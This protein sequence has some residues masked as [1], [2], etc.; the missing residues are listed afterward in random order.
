M[1]DDNNPMQSARAA[2]RCCARSKCT[3][4]PYRAPAVRGWRV[5]QLHG[6]GGGHRSG[7]DHPSWRHGMRAWEWLDERHMLNELVREAH[8]ISMILA[9]PKP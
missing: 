3:G 1:K 8:D 7:R 5:C 9:W 4:Q 6:A 2:P